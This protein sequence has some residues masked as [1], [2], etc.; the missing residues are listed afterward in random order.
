MLDDRGPVHPAALPP[1]YARDGEPGHLSA[2]ALLALAREVLGRG[3]PFRFS[4]PGTSM[5]PF[6]RD[7][8]VITLVPPRVAPVRA[9]DVVAFATAETGRLVVHRVL[10]CSG[11]G[12]LI[13]GDNAPAD[14]GVVPHA[15]IVGAVTRVERAGRTVRLGLGPERFLISLLSRWGVL[16]RITGAGRIACSAARRFS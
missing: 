8:D 11:D 1:S 15:A 14:D 4:A 10:S 9:G 13:R 7:G 5:S 16:P 12:C 3:Q 2:P 6:I